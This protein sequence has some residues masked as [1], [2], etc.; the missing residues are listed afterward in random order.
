ML[1]SE[2]LYFA[3]FLPITVFVYWQSL[4]KQKYKLGTCILVLASIIFYASWSIR[5]FGLLL[6]SAAVNYGISHQLMSERLIWRRVFFLFGIG[7]NM[8]LLGYFKYFNFFLETMNLHL[9]CKFQISSIILPLGISFYTFQQI[10][11]V[12]DAYKRKVQACAFS[13]YLLFVIYFPQLVAGPI[14]HYADILPQFRKIKTVDWDS[15]HKGIMVFIFGLAKK[16]IIADSL[17]RYVQL[18][19][20]NIDQLGFVSAWLISLSYTFQLYFDFSAYADMAIGSGLLFGIQ[21]P[22]NFNSPYKA[23]SIQDFWRRWH[24]TLSTW[25]KDYIYIPLGGSRRGLPRTLVNLFL[26]FLIGGIWHGAGWNFIVWG[27]LHGT[28]MV[29]HHLWKKLNWHLH[30]LVA[31]FLTFNFI[32][33]TWIF[34]RAS[35]IQDAKTMIMKLIDLSWIKAIQPHLTLKELQIL[36]AGSIDMSAKAL[37]KLFAIIFSLI[38]LAKLFKNTHQLVQKYVQPHWAKTLVVV[39]SMWVLWFILSQRSNKIDFLYWQF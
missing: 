12:V 3:C 5:F 35:S 32:H 16:I 11:Y 39:L 15:I 17:A 25:L 21:L 9:G 4:H 8:G 14:V 26:T 6:L 28:A 23:L 2:P 22:E 24:I 1:F 31:W 36:S 20:S 18:G 37:I 13:E 7:F 34:F 10:A 19:Y 38:L 30:S 27:A 29:G 33:L